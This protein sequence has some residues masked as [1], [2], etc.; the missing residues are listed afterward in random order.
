[1]SV[2][3]VIGGGPAGMMTAAVAA[4]RGKKGCAYRKTI[5]LEKASHN[6]QRTL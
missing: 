1:M 2:V 5:C 3:C 6:W 4:A